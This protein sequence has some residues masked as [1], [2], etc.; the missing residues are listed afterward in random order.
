MLQKKDNNKYCR[1]EH[2]NK[3]NILRF[4]NILLLIIISIIPSIE[5]KLIKI[6]KLTLT[7]EITIIIIGTGNQKILGDR[8]ANPSQI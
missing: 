7:N 6:K 4:N 8:P 2:L 5:S 3:M 1:I